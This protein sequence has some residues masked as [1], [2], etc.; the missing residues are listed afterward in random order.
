VP[1]ATVIAIAFILCGVL[2]F[3]LRNK[4]ANSTVKAVIE[5]APA[6]GHQAP[7]PEER[8]MIINCPA[9]NREVSSAAIACP[10][11]GHP[12]SPETGK[13]QMYVE[14]KLADV[15]PLPSRQSTGF[16]SPEPQGEHTMVGGFLQG[17]FGG[18]LQFVGVISILGGIFAY[19]A[20]GPAAALYFFGGIALTV[21][22]GYM[23]YASR[24]TVRT[25]RR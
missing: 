2:Y 25:T 8:A 11:C 18:V 7:Q 3:V 9:C 22:G 15:K 19:F 6:G 20:G 4:Q 16:L 24:H 21:I 1:L 13:R 10:G 17:F 12:I 23:K 5:S 14:G